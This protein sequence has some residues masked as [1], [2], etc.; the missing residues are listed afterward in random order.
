MNQSK[1]KSKANNKSANTKAAGAATA[2]TTSAVNS[3]VSAGGVECR[4]VS[5]ALLPTSS[6]TSSSAAVKTAVVEANQTTNPS[7][8]TMLATAKPSILLNETNKISL[9]TKEQQQLNSKQK[10]RIKKREKNKLKKLQQQLKQPEEIS[11]QAKQ[12]EEDEEEE[13]EEENE[14]EEE[15]D[16]LIKD[17]QIA[18]DLQTA[19]QTKCTEFK[20]LNL[21][22][23]EKPLVYHHTPTDENAQE[24]EEE[25]EGVEEQYEN[26]HKMYT[27][28]SI[29]DEPGIMAHDLF[30]KPP[31]IYKQVPP[32]QF[33]SVK[34]TKR[35]ESPEPCANYNQTSKQ[36]R[37]QQQQQ[38]YNN[39]HNYNDEEE[40]DEHDEND[41]EDEEDDDYG[42]EE[43][44]SIQRDKHLAQQQQQQQQTQHQQHGEAEVGSDNEEQEDVSDYCKGGYHPVK[45]GD[46]YAQRYHV[47]RKLGWGH[48]STV[49]LCWDFKA[50]RFVAL[51]IVKS[52]KHYT[53]AA[54]DEIKLLQCARDGDPSDENRY[55]TVQLLDDFKVTGP[56]GVHVCMVF[57][58]LGNNLL[59]LIIKSNYHGIPLPNVKIIV[60]QVLQGLDYLHRKCQIIHTDMKPENVL[61]CVDETHVRHLAQEAAEWQRLGIRPS[62]SAVAT[63]C[64]NEKS[65]HDNSYVN[66]DGVGDGTQKLS[67][68]KKKKL[69][70]KQK[71]I[72]TLLETQQKQIEL[73]QRENLNLLGYDSPDENNVVDDNEDIVEINENPTAA[74][75]LRNSASAAGADSSSINFNCDLNSTQNKRLSKL[76]SIN[77]DV[78]IDQIVNNTNSA[79]SNLN[80]SNN[81]RC[82]T[83]FML[84][85][86]KIVYFLF[87]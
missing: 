64:A 54:A 26:K 8:A 22:K 25:E 41:E 18:K 87:V 53:E 14:E 9:P 46:L 13:E 45:I 40:E 38:H 36:H 75:K 86:I 61:M 42:E 47:L 73:S 32:A 77:Q 35:I 23:N 63:L 30:I 21:I 10:K 76:I 84:F 33:Q 28:D 60:K 15:E 78:N 3:S 58:V 57:E 12:K 48:F 31:L 74:V 11:T 59:K 55:K 34:L 16:Q 39:Q 62:G 81:K 83:F 7:T 6:T 71:R 43:L 65:A 56:N 70:K 17:T 44:I 2:T 68:N 85:H 51:K 52:A 67:K 72:Q 69:R 27:I 50:I 19:T 20:T 29:C 4:V 66:E 80:S 79:I 82:V 1:K 49:W 5:E 37:L 24:E